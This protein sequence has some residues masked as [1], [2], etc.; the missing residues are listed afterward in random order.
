VIA[1]SGVPT[2]LALHGLPDEDL[3]AGVPGQLYD[4]YELNC[5]GIV[6]RLRSLAG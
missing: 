1:R 4:R 3:L 2:K 5:G 6:A